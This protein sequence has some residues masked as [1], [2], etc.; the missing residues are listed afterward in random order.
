MLRLKH[1]AIPFTVI[2][3]LCVLPVLGESATVPEVAFHFTMDEI[4]GDET[5][6]VNGLVGILE[7]GP[8]VVA[9][10]HGNAIQFTR[11][12]EQA[13]EIFPD[14]A[15]N[16]GNGDVSLEAWV[17]TGLDGEQS[18]IFNKWGP[19]EAPDTPCCRGYRLTIEAG[20]QL[21][22]IFNDGVPDEERLANEGFVR[23]GDTSVADGEWHHVVVTRK[24]T[25]IIQFWIDGVLDHE[26]GEA[27]A[28]GSI[29]NTT[30]L[31]LG[32]SHKNRG[33]FEGTIDEVR[34]WRGAL[35]ESQIAQAMAGAAV[36]SVEPVDKL[37][38]TWGK[39]K[40][41]R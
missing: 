5:R 26:I 7:N 30:N 37:S 12:S 20:G 8:E 1:L 13:I 34:A 25:S 33:W 15:T 10:M 11:A 18:Y 9:G 41:D 32:R 4:N 14:P 27:A 6:D 28:A 16:F 40:T 36:T 23:G 21:D 19:W 24:D 31:Y 39:I 22:T 3:L 38:V 35:N 17:K 2:A 29:D